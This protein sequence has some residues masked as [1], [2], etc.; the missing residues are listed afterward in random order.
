M[1]FVDGTHCKYDI[2]EYAKAEE[3]SFV[4]SGVVSSAKIAGDPNH[5]MKMFTAIVVHMT[6][7]NRRMSEQELQRRRLSL[8]TLYNRSR[9]RAVRRLSCPISLVNSNRMLLG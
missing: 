7:E 5:A 8:Y 1:N 2:R 3:S 9:E 4:L 6:P